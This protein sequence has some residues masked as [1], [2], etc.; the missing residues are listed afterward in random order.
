MAIGAIGRRL[1]GGLGI[2]AVIF[3]V[4][5]FIT[6]SPAEARHRHHGRVV[7]VYPYSY[8]YYGYPYR[9][10]ARGYSSYSPYARP[11]GITPTRHP[12]AFGSARRPI[13][14]WD[15]SGAGFPP[16]LAC[17]LWQ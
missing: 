1:G 10:Y 2:A 6:A 12:S 14:P 3:A 16:R 11:S 8:G 15:R 7:G 9:S 5:A 13:R 4:V 17:G